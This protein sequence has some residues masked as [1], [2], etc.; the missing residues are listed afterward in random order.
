MS[1]LD[2]LRGD[3]VQ[4]TRTTGS[5][6]DRLRQPE[7]PEFTRERLTELGVQPGVAVTPEQEEQ[8]RAGQPITPRERTLPETATGFQRLPEQPPKTTSEA[9]LKGIQLGATKVGAG[10]ARIT[11]TL[12]PEQIDVMMGVEEVKLGSPEHP[13]A[14]AAGELVGEVGV[15]APFPGAVGKTAA[16]KI[17]T[18]MGTGSIFSAISEAGEGGTDEEIIQA[19]LI[20]AGISG[21]FQALAE[22]MK[23]AVRKAYN[24]AKGRF[25]SDDVSKLVKTAEQQK[26]PIYAEDLAETPLAAKA[27]TLAENVPIVGT[28]GGRKAQAKAQEEAATRLL[29]KTQGDIDDFAIEA[30]S[31]LGRQ[32]ERVR[33]K[34]AKL[35][36]KAADSLDPKGTISK[37]RFKTA[38]DEEIKRETAKGTRANQDLIKTLESF[39]DAPDGTFSV[40]R[41]QRSDLG[42]EISK[43]YKGE[44]TTIGAKGADSLQ[45]VKNAL[46]DD[47]QSFVTQK[48]GE[49]GIQQF[50][51]ANQYYQSKKLPFKSK[52]LKEL[53]KTNEP[54]KIIAFL[55]GAKATKSRAKILYSAL[56]QDGRNAVKASFVSDAI[57]K[58]T[59]GRKAFSA[60]S[61]AAELE[62]TEK[63]TNFFFRGRDR[64]ELNGLKV[65]MRK[66]ARAGQVAENPP[67]GAR[68]LLP[69][70]GVGAVTNF[71]ATVAAVGGFATASKILLQTNIGRNLLL[72]LNKASDNTAAVE[73]L[74]DKA[75][76][77]ISRSTIAVEND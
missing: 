10:L 70:V 40:V 77:V 23:I 54:E 24:A 12:T 45:R 5:L 31:S 59:Q 19:A 37:S 15:T 14:Q 30:Q 66:T 9:F 36:D 75:T 73:R 7:Q 21:G 13:T 33:E 22:P 62:K 16:A 44:N 28:V 18:A 20:G 47:I 25:T 76:E 49:K 51:I 57:E 64:E 65:L 8:L 43:Y 50:R 63:A 56:D 67:T 48:G 1:L 35:F 58:A 39:R 61:F 53:I 74:I 34:G 68:L 27:S 17:G 72:G 60:N 11:N 32:L 42:D 69:G 46:E 52:Q 38:I 4:E 2:R 26:I 6:L 3:T 29:K 55:K 71:G 41:E